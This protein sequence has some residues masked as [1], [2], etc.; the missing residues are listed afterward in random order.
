M[1]NSDNLTYFL[2]MLF[3]LI[4]IIGII[5]ISFS[6]SPWLG[7]FVVFIVIIKLKTKN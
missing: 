4:I 1:N 6:V 7:A 3:L 2:V 5:T